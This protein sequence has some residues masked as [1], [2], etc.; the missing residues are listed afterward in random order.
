MKE[1]LAI[2]LFNTKEDDLLH[3]DERPYNI[4]ERQKD[5]F[6][7]LG[8]KLEPFENATYFLPRGSD[9]MPNSAFAPPMRTNYRYKTYSYELR[10]IYDRLEL[11]FPDINDP[12]YSLRSITEFVSENWPS[13]IVYKNKRNRKAQ[14]NKNQKQMM[15]WSDLYRYVALILL[16]MLVLISTQHKL[17]TK[18]V[19]V[20]R[21]SGS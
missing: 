9:G 20:I 19:S 10:D 7:I 16:L 21:L 1:D 2:I 12:R 5:L 15:T 11:L 14:K 4:S 8:L 18:F 3:I 6:T 17:N 13:L